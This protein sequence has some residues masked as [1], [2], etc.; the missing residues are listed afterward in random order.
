MTAT[1]SDG[2]M[3]LI[4]MIGMPPFD[5]GGMRFLLSG[6]I[7]FSFTPNIRGI[8]GPVMSPSST[9]TRKPR[10]FRPTARSP[11]TSDFPTPP[12][13]DMHALYCLNPLCS[14]LHSLYLYVL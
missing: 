5:F 12:L 11:A 14:T 1:S 3:R 2:R 4:D 6:D 7:G 9:P 10:R 13:P 8:E